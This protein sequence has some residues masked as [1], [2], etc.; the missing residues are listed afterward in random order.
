MRFSA[1]DENFSARIELRSAEREV[2]Y[3]AEKHTFDT[4]KREHRN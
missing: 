1:N 3:E 2:L 4:G